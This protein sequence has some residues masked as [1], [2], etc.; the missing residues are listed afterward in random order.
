MLF[1]RDLSRGGGSRASS[2]LSYAPTYNS[3]YAF[4]T[5]SQHTSLRRLRHSVNSGEHNLAHL[6]RGRETESPSVSTSF[7]RH[8]H[9]TTGMI[10]RLGLKKELHGHTGCVNC[11]E[12]NYDGSLLAS[13]SDDLSVI[14]WDPLK[15]RKLIKIRTGHAGNIFSV[16]F[17]PE[18]NDNLIVTGA[19]DFKIRV[20]DLNALHATDTDSCVSASASSPSFLARLRAQGPDALGLNV[21]P[22]QVFSSHVGR[23]KRL[24][25]A[26]GLPF[27]FWSGA[28]DGLVMEFDLRTPDLAHASN[29]K[30]VLINLNDHLGLNAE[31]KCLA[32]NPL[33]PHLLA[34]GANDPF[35]RVFDRRM[36]SCTS[37][38]SPNGSSNTQGGGSGSSSASS[39]S[40][41]FAAHP[42]EQRHAL[43][44]HL[45]SEE[46]ENK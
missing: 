13:G 1:S 19:A 37:V 45:L 43:L 26:P 42:W 23:V 17:M 41:R 4:R 22:A 24:A 27:T 30:N 46:G 2:D 12:W 39:T 14:I 18:T 10:K 6:L 8:C 7:R 34:V 33:R 38:K 28:E 35:V 5:P 36:L 32:V 21:Q 20:H 29:P 11:L 15:C 16:K 40:S 9:V 44:T 3:E 25:T 31:V